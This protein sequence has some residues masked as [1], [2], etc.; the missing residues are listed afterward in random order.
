MNKKINDLKNLTLDVEK[1]ISFIEKLSKKNIGILLN[2]IKKDVD[3]VNK[4]AL[5][6]IIVPILHDVDN[7]EKSF[8]LSSENKKLKSIALELKNILKL[9]H[10]LLRKYRITIINDVNVTFDPNIHQAI[11]VS[12][13]KDVKSNYVISI[14]QKGYKLH[15]RILRPAMVVVSK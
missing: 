15:E 11:A 13:F 9:F 14:M 7:L 1:E 3:N 12:E 10:N 5:S 6:N 8:D 4:Y 2:R